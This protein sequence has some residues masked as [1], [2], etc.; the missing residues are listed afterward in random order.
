MRD[1]NPHDH[2]AINTNWSGCVLCSYLVT[3]ASPLVIR[4]SEIPQ[5]LL[6]KFN[7]VQS[8]KV[9]QAVTFLEVLAHIKTMHTKKLG[10]KPEY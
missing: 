5:K 2:I 10:S 1:L 9:Y 8:F 3:K 4:F 7:K 6:E